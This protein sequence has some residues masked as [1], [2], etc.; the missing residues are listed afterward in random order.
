MALGFLFALATEGKFSTLS[1]CV[2]YSILG[3]AMLPDRYRYPAAGHPDGQFPMA[4]SIAS[5]AAGFAAGFLG[6]TLCLDGFL[7]AILAFHL[8]AGLAARHLW[9]LLNPGVQACLFSLKHM[10]I[11]HADAATIPAE[12]NACCASA[13]FFIAKKTG[14]T[15]PM[16]PAVAAYSDGIQGANAKWHGMPKWHSNKDSLYWP[17]GALD[18]IF[19]IGREHRRT[20]LRNKKWRARC[21]SDANAEITI[22]REFHG[23]GG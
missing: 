13:A 8:I 9:R 2:I 10:P 7:T 14:G 6:G 18:S 4:Q 1:G 5:G 20:L 21:Y 16:E 22:S 15:L 17:D 19:S 12:F 11:S 3:F 23:H